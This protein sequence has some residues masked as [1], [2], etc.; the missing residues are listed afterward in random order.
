MSSPTNFDSAIDYFKQN[1][2]KYVIFYKISYNQG[3]IESEL[4]DG[5]ILF[6]RYNPYGEYSFNLIFSTIKYDRIRFDNFDDRWDVSSRPH[7]FHPRGTKYA[8]ISP[9]NGEPTHDLAILDDLIDKQ[10]LFDPDLR[11]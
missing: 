1:F 7:H 4:Q 3:F 5:S 6:I 10:L 9:M 8:F 11:F 2:N